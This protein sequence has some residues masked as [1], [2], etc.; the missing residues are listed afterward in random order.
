MESYLGLGKSQTEHVLVLRY[1]RVTNTVVLA[2]LS[3]KE[4][5]YA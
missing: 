1:V 3:Y 4:E 5:S 2:A